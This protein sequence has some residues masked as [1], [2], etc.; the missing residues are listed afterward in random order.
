MTNPD[1]AEQKL[2]VGRKWHRACLR[3]E[4]CR[5][6]LD[7]NRVEEGPMDLWEQGCINTWCHMCYSKVRLS[8]LC[9]EEIRA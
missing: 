2:A 4:G 1:F 7:T 3:C 9:G 5:T 6:T 8:Y